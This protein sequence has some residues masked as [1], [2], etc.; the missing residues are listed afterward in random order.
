MRRG[1]FSALWLSLSFFLAWGGGAARALTI[2]VAPGGRDDWSGTLE[3]PSPDGSDGPLAT[4][5][6]ARDAIRRWK[7]SSPRPE[8]VTVLVAGGAYLISETL[9]LEPEDSG[10]AEHP[11]VYRAAPGARPVFSGGRE[12]RG[13]RAGDDGIWRAE[14]PDAAAGRWRFEQLFVD[15]R[16]AVRAREPDEFYFYMVEVKEDVLEGSGRRPRRARHTV[17]AMR[18]D[19]APLVDLDERELND[20]TL[21]A[22]HK[23]D[24]T[25]RR[26]G[27]VDAGSSE[28]I[29]EGEGLKSW[30]PWQRGTRYHLENFLAALDE[31]GEWFLDR[32]GTLLYKPLPGEDPSKARVTAPALERFISVEGDPAAGKYVEHIAIQGLAFHHGQYLTPPGGFESAQAA[33]PIDAVI[34]LDGARHVAIEDCEISHIG[35]Y[36]VWFRKGCRQCRLARCFLH[37]LGA[38][39]ARIGETGIRASEP[40]RTGG[41]AID[42]N[43]IRSAGHIFPCAVGVWI[44]QSG[45]NQVTH[46]D[47]GDLYYTGVSVGWRWGYAESLAKRNRIEFNRIHHIGWGVLSD[48]GGV[49]TLGPSEG[50]SVSNNVI[51]DV[52][53]YTYGGWGLYTD[54]G[55]TGI[56]ME[57]NLVYRVKNGGFHQHY[58]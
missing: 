29:S 26:I 51:H 55:S 54:E 46:N 48:M 49:Y 8:A 6:G 18:E 16:R 32:G 3:R 20:V 17:R 56:L 12:I 23:W 7:A 38:G 57:N 58:G 24:N 53:A 45:D 2:H 9:V 10:T 33:S 15:G 36:A 22:Y 25:R 37:D 34:E 21:V 13:L 14:I 42:N 11:I 52:H 39:G 40:E 31:P 5:A 47:I 27:R 4:L 35:S 41:I 44:G 19:M 43:I 30:N 1:I 50:T 28:I